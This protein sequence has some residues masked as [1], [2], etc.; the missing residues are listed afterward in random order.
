MV[1]TAEELSLV[2]Q[3]NQRR[4]VKLQV[5]NRDWQSVGVIRGRLISCNV[6]IDGTSTIQRTASLSIETEDTY[7]KTPTSD[8][9]IDLQRDM[10]A[11][12]YI[13]LWAGIEDNNTLRVRWYSQGIY[14][15]A[16]SSYTFDPA[17]RTLSVSLV[18]LMADLDGT[19][20][21][22]L[23][24]YT[25]LV[26]NQQRI[27]DVAKNIMELI[28]IETYSIE[29]ITVLRPT[30]SPIDQNAKESDYMVPYDIN[31]NAGVTAY[32]ILEKLVGL[33]PYYEMGF[34]VNGMFYIRKQ[35]LEQD[36]SYVI[37]PA[38]DYMDVVL[39]E[40][41]SIDW[42]YVKNHIEVW[43]KDGKCYGEADDTNPE[44]LFQ[45]NSTKLRTLV[46]TDN[47]YG[48][49][50]N[51]IC[52]RYKDD[53]KAEALQKEQASLEA[54]I[55]RLEAIEKPTDKEKSD[56]REAKNK[57]NNNKQEQE[58][59]IDIKGDDLAKEW[60]ERILYDR[61]RLQDSITIKTVCMPFLNDTGFK[62]SYRSKVDNVIRPYVVK[63]INHDF[64]GGTTTINMVRFY[65]DMCSNLW[66]QLDTP[67]VDSA[68]GVGMDI[69]VTIEDVEYAE[70]YVLYIDGSKRGTYTNTTIIYNVP[71]TQ[72]G[73]HTIRI[74]AQAPYYRSSELS[75]AV[76]VTVAPLPEEREVII[77]NTGDYLVTND[78]FRIKYN[79]G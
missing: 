53:S 66:E 34:D 79:E 65:N 40:D 29:P 77:T 75:N 50:T 61:T 28:G 44:S 51:N 57:L 72:A 12:Y 20:S 33:Y 76:S 67:V 19:R 18:D 74:K 39:S 8:I 55:S 64:S 35:L 9:S 6:S 78:G 45:I 10:P 5:I 54:E 59:N 7:L 37:L 52:D 46:V 62:M 42:N 36:D 21:G 47:Q 17:T 15:I 4:Y 63:S 1:V 22:Q 3:N 23:H 71:D 26:K 27:D 69:V 38:T 30:N 41:T 25:S 14:I 58:W 49:D 70:T 68:V 73:T 13:K 60:A 16:Q 43:G 56:L 11:D 2:K 31:F 32:E 24:A 48:V